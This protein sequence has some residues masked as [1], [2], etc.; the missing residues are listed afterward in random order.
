MIT[1]GVKLWKR[2]DMDPTRRS[3]FKDFFIRKPVTFAA[4]I[5][6]SYRQAESDAEYFSSV[7]T[8]YPLLSEYLQFMDDEANTLGIDTDGKSR[9]EVAEEIYRKTRK[10]SGPTLARKK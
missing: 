6:K 7:E 10:N 8:G 4:E 5:Q 9:L 1:E 2:G 3:F